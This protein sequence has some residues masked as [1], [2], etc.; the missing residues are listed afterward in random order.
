[1][2]QRINASGNILLQVNDGHEEIHLKYPGEAGE[3]VWKPGESLLWRL[4][5]E[6]IVK[7]L[8]ILHGNSTRKKVKFILTYT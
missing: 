7:E 3:F 1:M 4:E 8:L 2:H 6:K 5:T